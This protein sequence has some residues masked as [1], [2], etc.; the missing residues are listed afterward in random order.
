MFPA[1]SGFVVAYAPYVG[2]VLVF[3]ALAFVI[4]G[5]FGAKPTSGA[6]AFYCGFNEDN[7]I[8]FNYFDSTDTE[9]KIKGTARYRDCSAWYHFVFVYNS[10]AG[11]A[12]DRSQATMVWH[13]NPVMNY[14]RIALTFWSLSGRPLH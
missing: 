5:F 12:S 10:W 3:I 13:G 4:F 7:E 11:V 6:T 9:Y 8:N 14:S 1:F 2:T